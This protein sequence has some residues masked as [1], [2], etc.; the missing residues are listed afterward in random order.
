MLHEALH[1]LEILVQ[2]DFKIVS[3]YFRT[4]FS[5]IIARIRCFIVG[6]LSADPETT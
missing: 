4:F 5:K 6:D 1:V 2:K 3:A